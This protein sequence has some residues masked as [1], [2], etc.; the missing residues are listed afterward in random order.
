MSFISYLARAGIG[1]RTLDLD[2]DG[3]NP[4]DQY[5]VSGRA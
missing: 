5:S 4:I 3:I 1:P 2:A